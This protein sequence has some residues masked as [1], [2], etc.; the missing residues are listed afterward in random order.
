[1]TERVVGRVAA[2]WRHPVKSMAGES[3]EAAEVSWSGIAGDRRWAFVQDALVRSNFPWLTIR[4][5]PEMAHFRPA[6]EHP[7]DPEGSRTLVRCPSGRELDVVDPL[8]AAELGGGVRVIKQNR[9]T[10]DIMPLS[11]VSTQTIAAI[12]ERLGLQLDARRFR[13]GIVVE[14]DPEAPFAEDGW[15]GGVLRIGTMAM[16]VDQRDQR[17]V[18]VNVDPDTTERDPRVLRTIAQERHACLGVYG[19]T[20]QPGRIAVGDPVA[21]AG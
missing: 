3:L 6:F 11:L 2:L 20:M 13:P 1:M 10:F 17:C 14:A 4:E 8:L 9:G 16:R 7:N 18:M 12:G 15:V 21:L 19:S 5:R